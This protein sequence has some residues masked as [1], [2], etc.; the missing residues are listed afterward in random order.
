[1]LCA[2]KMSPSQQDKE[3][4]AQCSDGELLR[5]LGRALEKLGGSRGAGL[6]GSGSNRALLQLGQAI[7]RQ[8]AVIA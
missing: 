2:E 1:V 8:A 5:V 6:A 7:T 4:P 3:V